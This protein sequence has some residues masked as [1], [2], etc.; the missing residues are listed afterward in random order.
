MNSI[1]EGGAVS[2]LNTMANGGLIPVINKNS[3]LDV[4]HIGYE[5]YT[6]DFKEIKKL[7]VNISNESS[8]VLLEKSKS[9][10]KEMDNNYSFDNYQSN[11]RKIFYEI[12]S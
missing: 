12:L 9:I 2:T 5:L 11:I 3:G 1:S 8:S 4:Y 7:I 10:I 6:N